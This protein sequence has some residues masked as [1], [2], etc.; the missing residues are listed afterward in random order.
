MTLKWWKP[1]PPETHIEDI[2]PIVGVMPSPAKDTLVLKNG[3]LAAIFQIQGKDYTGMDEEG[4][5]MLHKVRNEAFKFVPE[6]IVATV[7]SR[8]IRQISTATENL[9]QIETAEQINSIWEQ[10]FSYSYHNRHFIILTTTNAAAIDELAAVRAYGGDKTIR[11]G[12]VLEEACT[13]LRQRLNEY[14]PRRLSGSELVSVLAS[15][16]NGRETHQRYTSYFGNLLTGANL[17]FPDDA[18]YQIFEDSKRRY[19]TW[20]GIKSYS[21]ARATTQRLIDDILKL[22]MELTIFN[23][24]Q[25][26][27]SK[28]ALKIVDGQKRYASE[29]GRYNSD[30]DTELTEIET[31]LQSGEIAL[32]N[33][34]FTV[35]VRADSLDELG[36]HADAIRE[37]VGHYGFASVREKR[38]NTELLFLSCLPGLEHLMVRKRHL[39][40]ENIADLCTF[41]TIGEGFERCAWG[42]YP[43]TRFLSEAMTV[44][45]FTFHN[46]DADETD[47]PPGHTLVFG[48]TGRGKT[49]LIDFLLSQC[50]KYD[51]LM[52]I[53]LDRLNGQRVFTEMHD[54]SYSD[55]GTQIDI[56][57]LQL[58]DSPENRKFLNQFFADIAGIDETDHKIE[59]AVR[60][61]YEVL[62]KTDRNID[63]IIHAFGLPEK[64]SIANALLP[65]TTKGQYGAFFNAAADSLDFSKS[66]I[67]AFNMDGILDDP[68]ISGLIL[69]YIFHRIRMM[70]R[71]GDD[72]KLKSH[73]IFTDELPKLLESPAFARHFREAALEHRKLNGVLLAA[74]QTPQSVTNHEVGKQILNSFANFIFHSDPQADAET[75]RVHYQLTATEINWIRTSNETRKVL[76]KRNGG[77]STILRTDLSCLGEYLKVFK[78]SAAAW[79]KV[80]KFKKSHGKNWK[81]AYLCDE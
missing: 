53:I 18:Q 24:F 4:A 21:D 58:P 41:T 51:D 6:N 45:S 81:K 25:V 73:V 23:Q 68:K 72:G 47:P 29:W 65:Y 28:K 48:G 74:A 39:S 75:L 3:H 63:N 80:M 79:Q 44:F 69:R 70:A 35:Q 57:P 43:V 56:N 1:L 30:I 10:Q 54:G 15:Y 14:N 27:E 38:R 13:T 22:Q 52:I 64:G 55:F 12:M 32:C 66:R 46:S 2:L 62:E 11:S 71:P 77:E 37:I 50:L 26:I 49:T 67:S 34:G 76:F 42:P 16:L 60:S 33:Y 61:L 19:A 36:H 40:T 5:E 17:I 7:Q 8:R 9:H 20:I 78:S 59:G 31:R